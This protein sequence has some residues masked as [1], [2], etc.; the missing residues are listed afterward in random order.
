MVENIRFDLDRDEISAVVSA[1]HA[2]MFFV[3]PKP[4]RGSRNHL[5][6]FAEP[7]IDTWLVSAAVGKIFCGSFAYLIANYFARRRDRTFLTRLRNCEH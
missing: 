5:A 4:G 6:F 7:I 1:V 3:P 2:H